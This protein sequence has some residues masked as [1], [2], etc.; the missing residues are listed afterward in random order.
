MKHIAKSL[1]LA[2]AL[3]GPALTADAGGIAPQIVQ[4]IVVAEPPSSLDSRLIAL[5]VLVLLVALTQT[6]QAPGC[7][8]NGCNG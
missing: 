4:E 6:Q 8:L 5:L 7:Q 2:A 3:T 1:I